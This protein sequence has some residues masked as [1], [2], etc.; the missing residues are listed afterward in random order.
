M[1]LPTAQELY[2]VTEATWPP[3]DRRQLDG[4]IIRCGDG[5]G[6]RVSAATRLKPDPP[7]PADIARAEA[8]MRTLGQTPLFML[9]D[10]EAALDAALAARGYAL[11]DPVTQYACP[12]AELAAR[13]VPAMSAFALWPPLAIQRE[14]W[15]RGGIGKARLRVM[16]R[17]RVPRTALL[18]RAHDRAAGAAFVAIE[19]KTAMIHAM[20]VVP[21]L[22]RTGVGLNI[23]RAAAHWAQD[24][25]ATH[26]SLLVT[27]ANAAA[28]ALYLAAGMTA[29]GKYHYRVRQ[30]QPTI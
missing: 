17:V 26:F 4:W 28:N 15:A 18:A 8:A 2:A 29:V 1:T 20:E 5:G 27:D 30:E 7:D 16:E 6:Q 11:K 14:I 12:I 19:R 9:R 13:P 25:G 21:A 23:L 24:H 22:R 10:G 3:A